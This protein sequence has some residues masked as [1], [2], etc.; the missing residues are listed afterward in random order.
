MVRPVATLDLL[1]GLAILVGLAGIAVPILPGLPIVWAAIVVW[2]VVGDDGARWIV[3]AFATVVVVAATVAQFLVPGR[4]M[5]DAG[6]PGRS[7][8][9]GA[10]AGI[11]GFFVVPVVGLFLFFV[12]GVYLAERVRLGAGPGAWESTVHALKG[13]G[14]SILIELAGGLLASAAWLAAVIA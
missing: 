7:I 5:L 10:L 2:A 11:I 6:V 12:A 14:L 1:A 3:L 9:I 4:R 13:V 8:T